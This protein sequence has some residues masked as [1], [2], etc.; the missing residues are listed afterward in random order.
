MFF[1]KKRKRIIKSVIN[2]VA[3][4]GRLTIG[5]VNAFFIHDIDGKAFDKAVEIGKKRHK[6]GLG[7][8]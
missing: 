3:L 6:N 5:G 7:L 2:D 4:H 8:I 1:N